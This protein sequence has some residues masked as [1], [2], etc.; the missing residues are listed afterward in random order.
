LTSPGSGDGSTNATAGL[1]RDHV[2]VA[3]Y[4]VLGTWAWFLYGFGAILP[5]LR[6]EEGISRSV[7]GLHSLALASG[8]L[9]S[10]GLAMPLVRLVRRRGCFVLGGVLLLVGVGLLVTLHAPALTI[11]AVGIIGIGGSMLVN[12]AAPAL[13]DHH[14]GAAAAAISEGNAFAAAVGLLAPTT[15]GLAVGLGWTWRPAALLVVPL[16]ALLLVMV[17]RVP[18]GTPAVDGL[19][20][21]RVAAGGRLPVLPRVLL[22]LVVVSVGIEFCCTA[23]AADL[24]RT[25]TGVSQGVASTGVTAVVAGMAVGRFV[26][27]RLALRY[28]PRRL[29]FG[30]QALTVTGWLIAW[31]PAHP[32]AV[33]GGLAVTGLGIAALYPLGTSLLYAAAPG[34][35]DRATGRLSLGIAVAAGGGPFAIGAWADATSTH[36]AFVAVPLLVCAATAALTAATLIG[37]SATA[38]V[39]RRN[40]RD[41]GPGAAAG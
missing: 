29:L 12:T 37:R 30:A 16:V 4:V 23:W 10:G 38:P 2:T 1:V 14:G 41:V 11:T 20:G 17:R 28:A 32:V 36:T 3:G 27:G 35:T 31:L 7:L 19:P 39:G 26:V 40:R 9:V 13:S 34:Q 25:R 8:G 15:V 22:L 33:V 21:A 5:L 24:L 18:L 6:A